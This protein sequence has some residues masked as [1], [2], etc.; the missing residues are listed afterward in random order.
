MIIGAASDTRNILQPLKGIFP[1]NTI[2]ASRESELEFRYIKGPQG[3][4]DALAQ[5]SADGK[6][7]MLDFYADWCISCKEM[8]AYTFSDPNVQK[9]LK[10]TVLLKSDVTANDEQDKALLKQFGL[11]GPPAILFFGKDGKEKNGYRVVGFIPPESF[12]PHAQ[13]A[14]N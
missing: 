2:S 13:E 12:A 4:S 3:L 11:I 1:S 10:N 8:E 14:L 6:T 7:A 5:A 9:V